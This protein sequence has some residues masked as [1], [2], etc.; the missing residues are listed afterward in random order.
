MLTTTATGVDNLSMVKLSANYGA[1]NRTVYLTG[2]GGG[3]TVWQSSDDGETFT[4]HAAPF[5]LSTW[6]VAGDDL[7]IAGV[8]GSGAR[9]YR[10]T[11]GA[12]LPVAGAPLGNVR[13]TALAVSPNYANDGT[14]LAGD[15]G[16]QVYLS[17][18][19]GTSFVSLGQPLPVNSGVDEISVAF[20]TGFTSNS[21]VYVASRAAV[22]AQSRQRLFRMTLGTLG[23]WESITATSAEGAT[24]GSLLPTSGCLW[25]TDS[26][27]VDT[28]GALGGVLRTL[29]PMSP[30]G[31]TFEAVI[32]GLSDGAV[33]EDLWASSYR[34]WS[35]DVQNVRIVTFFDSLQMPPVSGSPEDGTQGLATSGLRLQ[36]NPAPGATRYRWQVDYDGAFASVP[37]GLEGNTEATSK[38]LP[39]LTPGTTY[40]WR[41]RATEP[42]LSPWSIAKSFTTSLGSEALELMSPKAGADDVPLAPVF[43]WSAVPGAES[44]EMMVSTDSRFIDTVINRC[45]AL[46][47]PATAW[48]SD[49]NLEYGETY[50]WKVRGWSSTSFS[51]WSA[52]GAFTTVAP[53]PAQEPAPES[54]PSE[55]E[56]VE[57]E[58]EPQYEPVVESPERTE[59]VPV[60]YEPPPVVPV[61]SPKVEVI[62]PTW[63]LVTVIGL[64]ATLVLL[65][66]TVLFAVGRWR[67]Y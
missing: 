46:A 39:A 60:S 43:Q 38:R 18:D 32:N 22:S 33:L 2:S 48:Q 27:P 45:N 56:P 58:P 4:A 42:M 44:Y 12:F 8:D 51:A 17:T 6:T 34:V 21:T 49:T 55:A 41:V 30:N 29:D 20:D 9:V 37:D 59:P 40:Y 54:T 52:V 47:L 23:A 63:A 35:V 7:I 50:F 25:A 19:G 57:T 61:I 36:W 15:I 3:A 64:M 11:A 66:I 13:P 24:V 10:L 26:Q 14:V 62:I 1:A 28:A 31:A 16:G 5:E 53:P 65:L 67:R